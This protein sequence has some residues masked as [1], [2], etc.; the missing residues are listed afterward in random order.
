[1]EITAIRAGK[2]LKSYIAQ[3]RP[4]GNGKIQSSILTPVFF[5]FFMEETRRELDH[6]SRLGFYSSV[7]FIIQNV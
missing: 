3:I 6:L 4:F 1:M 2:S 7:P 5:F